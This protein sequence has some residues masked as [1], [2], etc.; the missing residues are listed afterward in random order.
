MIEL[1]RVENQ[2]GEQDVEL[3]ADSEYLHVIVREDWEH[4]LHAPGWYVRDEDAEEGSF[5][6]F[7]EAFETAE[8]MWGEVTLAPARRLLVDIA[9]GRADEVGQ[10]L[11]EYLAAYGAVGIDVQALAEQVCARQEG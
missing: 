1:D 6:T 5:D 11:L 10:S 8:R 9:E 7:G 3:W 4:S 2:H